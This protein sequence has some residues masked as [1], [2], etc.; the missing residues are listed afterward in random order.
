MI[1]PPPLQLWFAALVVFQLRKGG[2]VSFLAWIVL[3][4]LAGF[5]GSKIGNKRVKGLI[6]DIILGIVSAV[7]GGWHVNIFGAE[8]AN[9]FLGW[10]RKKLC[11]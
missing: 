5:I 9:D 4:L 6:L 2:Q 10:E 1:G 3:G 8:A 7:L 11:F